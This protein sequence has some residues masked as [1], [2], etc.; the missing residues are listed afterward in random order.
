[1]SGKEVEKYLERAK[2]LRE[3]ANTIKSQH[4][5]ELLLDSLEK[6][7][8]LAMQMLGQEPKR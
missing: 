7:L 3:L 8:R 1:V 6:F 4:H 2:E 5:R